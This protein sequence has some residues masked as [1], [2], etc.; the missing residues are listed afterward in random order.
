MKK[1]LVGLVAGSVSILVTTNG[2]NAQ[3]AI[4]AE[5]L[6]DQ[7]NITGMK[8]MAF[9]KDRVSDLEGI[10]PRMVKQFT[11]VYKNVTGESW[12]KVRNGFSVKFISD[13]ISNLVYYSAGG[14]WAGSLKGYRENKLP[15]KIRDIVKRVYYDYS[16]TYVHEIET[17]ES[18]GIP[19][20]II[21]LE[22]SNKLKQVR[23]SD[24]QMDVW[25]ELNRN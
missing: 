14:K 13:D 8:K 11:K 20:Y 25:Q 22:D 17:A 2:A 23:V 9:A 19:T 7:K 4:N 10:N 1:Y 6:E 21:H 3:S 16:I 18:G 24:G 5:K 12:L 15:F